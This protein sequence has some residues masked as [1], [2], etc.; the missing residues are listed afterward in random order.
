MTMSE[1]GK[2]ILGDKSAVVTYTSNYQLYEI[3]DAGVISRML[4]NSLYIGAT[5]I[6]EE[7]D[8][9][10]VVLMVTDVTIGET[11]KCKAIIKR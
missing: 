8:M 9:R 10:Q 2:L 5:I 7:A 1:T 4:L 3:Y 11:G 6:L